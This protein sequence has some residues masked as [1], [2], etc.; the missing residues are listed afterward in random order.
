M[1][2][3]AFE[4]FCTIWRNSMMENICN[5]KARF[6]FLS[7]PVKAEWLITL[8][9]AFSMGKILE[10][11]KK[12]KKNP[13]ISCP[14]FNSVQFLS[15]VQLFATPWI[16]AGQASLSITNF[17]SL[18]KL[19]PIESVMPSSYLIL[20]RPLLLLLSTFPASGSFPMSQLFAS[21]EVL[22]LQLQHQSFQW[23]PKI[24][25]L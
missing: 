1:P 7:V 25:F 4:A 22:E 12:W 9:S 11:K 6:P 24:D 13:K 16:A 19:M 3:K 17:Q 21:G 10:W 20:C 2:T 23:T 15:R 18:P 8:M 5:S 14:Q